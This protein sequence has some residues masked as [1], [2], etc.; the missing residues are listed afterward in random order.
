[1]TMALAVGVSVRTSTE[2]LLVVMR[3]LAHEFPFCVFQ[4]RLLFECRIDL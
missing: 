4:T 3:K 1:M 2:V